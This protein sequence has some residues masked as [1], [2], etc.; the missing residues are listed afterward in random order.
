MNKFNWYKAL[1]F[2]LGIWAIAFG[3]VAVAFGL[4]IFASVWTQVGIAAIIAVVTYAF[5]SGTRADNLG[6]ALG[7]GAVFAAVGIAL[8][9]IVSQQLVSGLFGLWTYYLAYAAILF[10]PS[11]QVLFHQSS[12]SARAV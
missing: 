11:V 8:D 9:L 1:G 5:A 10:A 7:Y 12:P 3:L 6:Q 4:G 2:G